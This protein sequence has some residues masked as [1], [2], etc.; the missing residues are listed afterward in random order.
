MY[1]PTVVGGMKIAYDD[2]IFTHHYTRQSVARYRCI[3]FD[4]FGCQAA[5][6]T[7]NKLT[8]PVEREHTHSG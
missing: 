5:I 8:Y 6:V 4:K 3:M 1:V 2:H 7:K